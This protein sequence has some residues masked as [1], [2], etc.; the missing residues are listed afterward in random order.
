MQLV[1]TVVS[2]AKFHLSQDKTSQ[3][4]VTNV[5]Q[6]INQHLEE[7]QVA[8]DL[9]EEVEAMV[10][11]AALEEEAALTE[12]HEKCTKQH[13][14]TVVMNAKFHLSQN[15]TSLYTARIVSRN[16]EEIKKYYTPFSIFSSK[17]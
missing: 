7:V 6:S 4:T 13:V 15:R 2:N 17:S 12:D 10:E 3:S 1:E 16:T 9:A 11:E 14:E 8:E 5:F